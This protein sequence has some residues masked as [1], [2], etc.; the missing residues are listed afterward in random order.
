MNPDD[1][2]IIAALYPGLADAADRIDSIHYYRKCHPRLFEGLY[3]LCLP[4]EKDERVRRVWHRVYKQLQE[5]RS[6]LG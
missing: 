3:L 1:I 5:D 4:K 2:K 6:K